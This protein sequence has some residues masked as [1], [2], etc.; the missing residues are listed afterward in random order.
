MKPVRIE[1]FSPDRIRQQ[2]HLFAGGL[3]RNDF[4]KAT[5]LNLFFAY[6]RLVACD[7]FGDFEEVIIPIGGA[8][9]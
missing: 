5:L 7:Y 4:L 6:D 1:L 2:N 8:V 9:H 3:L